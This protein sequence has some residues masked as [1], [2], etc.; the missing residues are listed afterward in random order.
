[1][2]IFAVLVTKDGVFGSRVTT[3]CPIDAFATAVATGSHW[4]ARRTN[5]AAGHNNANS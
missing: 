1:V 3:A 2:L 5:A 4:A